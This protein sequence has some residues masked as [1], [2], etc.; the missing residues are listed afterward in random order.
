MEPLIANAPPIGFW[1]ED[2]RDKWMG[3]FE[4]ETA[5]VHIGRMLCPDGAKSLRLVVL[6]QFDVREVA[7]VQIPAREPRR[8]GNKRS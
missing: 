8:K 5:A 1:I 6:G 2:G 3:P 7:L 4:S